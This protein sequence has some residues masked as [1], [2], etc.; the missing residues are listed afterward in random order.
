MST[1]RRLVVSSDSDDDMPAK[2]KQEH[3]KKAETPAKKRTNPL[4]L[5]DE[6]DT[7][8]EDELIRGNDKELKKAKKSGKKALPAGQTT[9]NFSKAPTSSGKREEETKKTSAKTLVNPADFFKNSPAPSA[10]KLPK[11]APKINKTVEKFSKSPAK[12]VSPSTKEN[13]KAKKVSD[14]E[15]VDS[16]D[17]FDTF[18]PITAKKKTPEKKPEVKA[19]PKVKDIVKA[20]EEPKKEPKKSKFPP[21]KVS[22]DVSSSSQVS[23]SSVEFPSKPKGPEPV[24]S[25]VDKYKPKR[26]GELVGQFGDKSPMN[27]LMEWLNDWA[28]HNLGEGAKV[29]KPKP[30]PWMASQDGTPF[31]A[32]LL[33][34]S[35]GV[36][37]TTCAYMACQQLGLKLVEMNA[38]DVR[39]R[40][41]LEAKIGELS[42]SHQ[43]EEFFGV[44]KCVPQDNSKV[45]HVLIMD[46]VD[47]M[48][49]NEDRAGISELIQI[50][51]E[52]K[53]PI[54]CI[55]NDRMHTK[56]R[57][58]ANY[59]YDLRF[60]KP[61]VEMIRSRMMTICSQEKLK[62]TKED[63]DEII[64]LSGH[65]VRQTIYNL[66][67]R[68]KSSNATVNKKDLAWGPF[69]AARR[70]LDS[71]TTLMEKQEMFFV[72]YGI[73]PLFVQENYLNMKNEKHKPLEAIRGLRK[74]SDLI[75]L[76]DIVDRQI[77]GGG[78]WKL[79]NEQSMLSA[80]LPAMATGGHLKAMLQF[81][82][83][84]GKNSSAGKKK[85]LLQQL[86]QHTH[87]RVSAGTHSFA[88][89]YAPMLR[90]KIT[91]PLIQH[92][93][94][95]IP[96]VIE[97]MTEY[98]LI[99]DDAEALTEIVTWPGKIDPA[100]K[101]LSKVKASLTRTLNKTSRMLP[102]SIDDVAKGKRKGVNAIG[103]EMDA[104]GN[105][106]EQFEDEDGESD[107]EDEKPATTE[108]IVKTRVGGGAA[109]TSKPARG[110]RG[111]GRGGRGGKK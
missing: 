7:S 52:S 94:D 41:H 44:K 24:L 61:R 5:S 11:V 18:T 85:R 32:A 62:I 10:S 48:S 46:E 40:K 81:P 55:C 16:D 91:K 93:A 31:K 97:T 98:D 34:G 50:I 84:L 72:D 33:S 49:G 27:K 101:I 19:I 56:I 75:S 53:I 92:E 70:L 2:P 43:I 8:E 42:G 105:L 66:Q 47:G 58:L 21:P 111:G 6:E 82:S 13:T 77:R 107:N 67:M 22:S 89:D 102:Y 87:L 96:A 17:S 69:E 110:G 109:G 26:L 29:K 59:C 68:S 83:W 30:A 9:L 65:D 51:K 37:K 86:V 88:T 28:K 36:G 23:T 60:P 95:G 57:S 73:M 99:K 100:S 106:V 80:A 76:G 45:H 38:S 64:E 1:K 71:R 25:W 54:I 15:F 12:K 4:V 20:E 78:S 103:I 90:Q 35:P 108:V 14:D 63:L 74:A 104:E 39:N 3:K 79:L